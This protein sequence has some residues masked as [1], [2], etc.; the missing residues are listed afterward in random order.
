MRLTSEIFAAALTRRVFAD[1]GFAAVVRRG[2]EAAGAV[3]VTVRGRDGSLRFYAPAP[4]TLAEPDGERRFTLEPESDD[5]ALDARL[6][7]E[8]RF[9]PD[10]WM[11]DI[12]TDTP[13]RYLAIV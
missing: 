9:D 8:A 5:E 10:F 13:E 6:R 2:A 4:Q 12:E 1:G 3:F 11:I 7:R